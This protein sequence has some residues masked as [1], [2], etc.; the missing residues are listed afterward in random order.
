[1]SQVLAPNAPITAFELDAIRFTAQGLTNKET[2][3][4]VGR[5]A[6]AV[7][8]SLQSLYAKLPALNAPHAVAVLDDLRPG[9]RDGQ[10]GQQISGPPVLLPVRL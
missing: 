9:W 4:Q 2:G 5:T 10:E 6:R 1:M 8:F 3:V 7:K